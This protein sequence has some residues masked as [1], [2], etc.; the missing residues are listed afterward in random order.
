MLR[1]GYEPDFVLRQSLR[2]LERLFSSAI[3]RINVA[4]ELDGLRLTLRLAVVRPWSFII[5]G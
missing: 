2:E 4:E 1:F 5:V 3:P